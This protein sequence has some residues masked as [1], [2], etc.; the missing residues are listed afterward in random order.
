MRE[1]ALKDEI[2]FTVLTIM[3]NEGDELPAQRTRP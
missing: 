1:K 2:W 3:L